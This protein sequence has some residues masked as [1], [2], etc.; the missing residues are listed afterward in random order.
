LCVWLHVDEGEV[1]VGSRRM[2]LG[3]SPCISGVSP[4][5]VPCCSISKLSSS[6]AWPRPSSSEAGVGRLARV[7][8]R[9]RR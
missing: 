7:A 6:S 3:E 4:L 1:P 9:A 2:K 5:T 8:R